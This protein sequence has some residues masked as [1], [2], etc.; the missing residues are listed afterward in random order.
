M[1]AAPPPGA[2]ADQIKTYTLQ[3]QGGVDEQTAWATAFGAVGAGANPQDPPVF[4]PG[5]YDFTAK[6]VAG[7]GQG[8]PDKPVTHTADTAA[9]TR[10]SDHGSPGD[11]VQEGQ[12][13]DWT[14]SPG[15]PSVASSDA[16]YWLQQQWQNQSQQYKDVVAQMVKA[17]LVKPGASIVDVMPWW[18][19]MVDLSATNTA[20]GGTL[21]PLDYL[22][23]FVA[24]PNASGKTTTHNTSTSR[25]K[26]DA[27]TIEAAV[28]N[29]SQSNLG[30]NATPEELAQ[31]TGVANAV[32]T[33]TVTNSTSTTDAAGN[34]VSSSTSSG[35]MTQ[36]GLDQ[37]L[38]DQ[39]MTSKDYG[40]YQAAGHYFP[41]LVNALS[42]VNSAGA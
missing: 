11:A 21:S 6:A 37:A 24:D 18:T 10:D 2:T 16:V 22:S 39:Q 9:S 20:R 40:A 41:L 14:Y 13:H 15:T 33:P 42:A 29:T 38:T 17:G 23:M 35:G 4:F 8:V 34:S 36:A 27:H 19:K 31:Q 30:R 28:E 5:A 32:N 7:Y 25:N 12:H 1:A 3:L 26:L